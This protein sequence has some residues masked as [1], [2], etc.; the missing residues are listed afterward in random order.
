MFIVV[1]AFKKIS[2]VLVFLKIV[3]FIFVFSLFS[4]VFIGLFPYHIFPVSHFE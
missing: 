3:K 2:Y 4:L 1:L